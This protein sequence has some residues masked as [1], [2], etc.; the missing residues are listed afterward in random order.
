MKCLTLALI[1]LSALAVTAPVSANEIDVYQLDTATGNAGNLVTQPVTINTQ[2]DHVDQKHQLEAISNS[3][4]SVHRQP[5]QSISP[6]DFIKNP[7]GAVKRFFQQQP[8]QNQIPQQ[9][10]PLDVSKKHPLDSFSR[11]SISIP[12]ANF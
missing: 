4:P 2:R 11:G 5:S 9:I 12:V 7:S 8:E 3:I 6:L 10:D 1:V